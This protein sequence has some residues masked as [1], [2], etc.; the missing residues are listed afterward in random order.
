MHQNSGNCHLCSQKC[1]ILCLH[2]TKMHLV[3]GLWQTYCSGGANALPRPSSHTGNQ[4]DSQTDTSDRSLYL[5]TKW[6][7]TKMKPFSQ[8]YA[9]TTVDT[10][11]ANKLHITPLKI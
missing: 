8:L 11:D 10:R 3:A 5:Y 1:A 2:C 9:V 6:S 4:T 7:A